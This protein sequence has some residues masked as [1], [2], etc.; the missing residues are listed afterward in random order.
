MKQY[1]RYLT[2][3]VI[4]ICFHI[5]SAAIVNLLEDAFTSDESLMCSTTSFYNKWQCYWKNGESVP[6][7]SCPT[8][9]FSKVHTK[10]EFG[11]QLFAYYPDINKDII[12]NSLP[13]IGFADGMPLVILDFPADNNHPDLYYSIPIDVNYP[14]DYRLTGSV[15][16]IQAPT[17]KYVT[18]PSDFCT[19][20]NLMV[21][22]ADKQPGKKSMQ[23]NTANELPCID[24][25]DLA[26]QN[27]L[28]NAYQSFF[29]SSATKIEKIIYLDKD[30]RYL[31]IYAPAVINKST[32]AVLILGNLRLEPVNP[33]EEPE[34]PIRKSLTFKHFSKCLYLNHTYSLADL[35]LTSQTGFEWQHSELTVSCDNTELI[36]MSGSGANTSFTPIKST[37]YQGYPTPLTY[38]TIVVTAKDDEG[39]QVSSSIKLYVAEHSQQTQAVFNYLDNPLTEQSE[40]SRKNRNERFIKTSVSSESTEIRTTSITDSWTATFTSHYKTG[41][42]ITPHMEYAEGTGWKMDFGDNTN[43]FR[44]H[45][46]SNM[47]QSGYTKTPVYVL[48]DL[49]INVD[50]SDCTDLKIY[51]K[52]TINGESMTELLEPDNYEDEQYYTSSDA[53][54]ARDII[55]EGAGLLVIKNISLDFL[56]NFDIPMPLFM[57]VETLG[58][59]YINTNN[60]KDSEGNFLWDSTNPLPIQYRIEPDITSES[61]CATYADENN[62]G[63]IDYNEGEQITFGQTEKLI[64]RTAHP[65]GMVSLPNMINYSVITGIDIPDTEVTDT[66]EFYNLQGLRIYGPQQNGV[67]IKVTNGKPEKINI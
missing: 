17:K 30:V 4:A 18:K 8:S 53:A 36:E 13:E 65:H 59:T 34:E 40:L 3:A 39:K 9:I 7:A 21:F 24:V 58:A 42:T 19:Q 57:N 64:A 48:K 49:S 55:F 16:M 33:V 60:P 56:C 31:S 52:Q 12:P 63:W 6:D 23:I 32:P 66:T 14:G 41:S 51:C 54:I 37:D 11:T 46:E 38:S 2:V 47:L 22:V 15:Q 28:E 35:G 44:L 26:N 67:Y 45:L 10:S 5:E 29:D 43:Q 62:S 20:N 25:T 50:E 61:A 1:L 27:L